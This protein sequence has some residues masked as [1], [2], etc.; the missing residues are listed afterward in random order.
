MTWLIVVSFIWA[1]SPGLIKGRLTDV[2]SSLVALIRVSLALI[3]FLPLLKTR[4]LGWRRMLAPTAIGA[5]QFG[6]MYVTYI[7]A[8]QFLES[9]Q[10]AILTIF[11]P[12]FV[13]LIDDV[14]AGRFRCWPWIA[15]LLATIGAG[16][17]V[18]NSDQLFSARTWTGVWLMQASNLCFAFG[19]VAYRRW[20]A[21]QI[22][23]QD[24]EIFALLYLGAVAV[25]LPAAV[26]GLGTVT[27][28]TTEHW[29][30]LIYL[31]LVASGLGFFLWNYGAVRTN[32]GSLAVMNNLKIPLMVAVSLLVFG[33]RADPV[34]LILGA[35]LVIAAGVL[36]EWSSRPSGA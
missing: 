7:A 17:I 16:I 18:F 1:F 8:F 25:T 12:L 11:T 32:T 23:V 27:S 3:V 29:L 14:I 34:R 24:R 21:K 30:S 13:C 4:Q 2:D 26:P 35:A 22:A 10:I 36:A 15:A 19:Q 6:L 20:R 5:V 9:Y 28:L 33:E 31:G